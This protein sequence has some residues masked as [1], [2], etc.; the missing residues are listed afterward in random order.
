MAPCAPRCSSSPTS[1]ACRSGCRGRSDTDIVLP[2]GGNMRV[3]VVALLAALGAPVALA[4]PAPASGTPQQLS[5][6]A[7]GV[8][9]AARSRLLQIRTLLVSAGRQSSIGSG[10][11][12]SASGLAI[13]NY[14]VVAQ[15]AL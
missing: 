13:T 12:V 5:S 4:Q 14:H 9:A 1:P 3:L 10:F 7:A 8:Y 6:A 11:L 15:Y 2:S